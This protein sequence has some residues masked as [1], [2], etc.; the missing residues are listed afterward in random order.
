MFRL[1][2]KHTRKP[3]EKL[4]PADGYRL[5][6]EQSVTRGALGSIAV[7]LLLSWF[8]AL[9]ALRS[10]LVFPWFSVLIGAL[11][12]LAVQR[13]GRGLDWRF[14]VVAVL[15]AGLAAYVGNLLIGVL[16]TAQ[17]INATPVQILGGLSMDT[18]RVFLANTISPTDHIYACSAGGVAA[19]FANRRLKRHQVLGLRLAQKKRTA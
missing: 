5:L 9:L 10:G 7:A 3:T 2:Q 16:Q 4:P 15:V 18:M 6:A 13:F 8:W 11:I 12:G 17:Y 19:F 1:K 14:P